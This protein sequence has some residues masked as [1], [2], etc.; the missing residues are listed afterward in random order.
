MPVSD[1]FRTFV[2]D[3]LGRAVPRIRARSMFGGVGIYSGELFF[4]LLANDTLYLKVDDSNRPDFEAR[5]MGPFLPFG[6]ERDKMQYYEVPADLLEDP[7]ALRPW[8]E[9]AIAVAAKK[10]SK[11]ARKS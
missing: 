5:G 7:D 4:A 8:A 3:Q 9:K 11:K 10:K 6:D 1:S 2:L